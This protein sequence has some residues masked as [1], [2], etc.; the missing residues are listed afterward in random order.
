MLMLAGREANSVG[1]LTTSVASGQVRDEPTNRRSAHV[2]RQVAWVRE[3]AGPRFPEIEL[4]LVASLLVTDQRRTATERWIRERG[5]SSIAPEEVWDMPAVLIG[6]VE[7][8]C[9][10]LERRREQLGFSYYIISDAQ[11][12]E[13]APIVA[14]M[15]GR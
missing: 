7:Q 9:E 1:I 10:D 5:W 12:D 13:F 8:I 14:R 3:G 6:T 4:S 11:L 2:A 15:T